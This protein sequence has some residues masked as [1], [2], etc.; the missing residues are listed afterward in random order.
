MKQKMGKIY[1]R[2]IVQSVPPCSKLLWLMFFIMVKLSSPGQ[3][4]NQKVYI[5]FQ[6]YQCY[7]ESELLWVSLNYTFSPV[8]K[9]VSG[10][11]PHFFLHSMFWFDNTLPTY[12]VPRLGSWKMQAEDDKVT[13]ANDDE[14]WEWENSNISRRVH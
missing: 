6:C 13:T 9:K 7:T 4:R 3:T 8:L 1:F 10:L 5:L 14:E 2:K 12:K 11:F